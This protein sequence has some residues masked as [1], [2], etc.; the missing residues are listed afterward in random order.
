MKRHRFP[1]RL[2]HKEAMRACVCACVCVCM[3][4]RARGR[5]SGPVHLI[6][7]EALSSALPSFPPHKPVYPL[8]KRPKPE[9]HS[10]SIINLQTLAVFET[11]Y[12][13]RSVR[14]RDAQGRERDIEP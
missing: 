6:C 7:K 14:C 3:C 2:R 10:M 13:A 4:V 8:G 5:Y 12:N 11:K 1:H 9:T